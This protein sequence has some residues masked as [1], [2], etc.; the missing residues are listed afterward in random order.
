MKPDKIGGFTPFECDDGCNDF[1]SVWGS[2]PYSHVM[3]ACHIIHKK[4]SFTECYMIQDPAEGFPPPSQLLIIVYE[5][6]ALNVP[7]RTIKSRHMTS[8]KLFRGAVYDDEIV[9]AAD[10][11]LIELNL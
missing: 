3:A 6:P 10:S 11:A 1:T 9:A 8:C 7:R 4:R 5:E 2:G